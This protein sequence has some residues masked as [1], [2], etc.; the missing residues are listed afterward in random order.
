MAAN[1]SPRLMT[2]EEFRRLPEREST[3]CELRHGVLV[4]MTVPK[5]KHYRIQRRLRELLQTAAGARGV[6]DTEFAYRALPEYEFRVADVACVS[7]E[8][9]DEIGDDDNLKGAPDLAVEVLSPSNTAAEIIDKERICLENGCREFWVVDPDRQLIKIS[10]PD[11][12]TRTYRMGD[13]IPPD[14]WH[15]ETI[16]VDVI[17]SRQSDS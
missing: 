2:V 12:L 9:W 5:F 8:R 14:L 13:S 16:A 11:G 15:E 6:A 10:T 3:Y 4:E 7:R 1:P 17:F